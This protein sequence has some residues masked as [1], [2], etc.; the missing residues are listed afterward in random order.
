MCLENCVL[1]VGTIFSTFK[2]MNETFV[3]ALLSLNAKFNTGNAI[4]NQ[5]KCNL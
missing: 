5:V 2:C 1:L 4:L 3:F